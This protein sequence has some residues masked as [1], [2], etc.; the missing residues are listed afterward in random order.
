MADEHSDAL[1]ALVDGGSPFLAF[2]A[3]KKKL[4]C[5]LNNH[6]LPSRVEAVEAF[7]K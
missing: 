1:A 2:T 6:E 4:V 5:T 7:V 3:D